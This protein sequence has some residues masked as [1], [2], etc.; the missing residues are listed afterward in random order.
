MGRI[1]RGSTKRAVKGQDS[2]APKFMAVGK[3]DY[4]DYFEG[5]TIS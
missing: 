2:T 5:F 4:L 3:A 1:V